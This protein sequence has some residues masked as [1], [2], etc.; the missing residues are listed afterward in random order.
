M[1][2]LRT[3]SVAMRKV[4]HGFD[5]RCWLPTCRMRFFARTTVR[6]A[7]ASAM[8]YVSGFW[9]WRS[10]PASTALHGDNRV[11]VIG[12]RHEDGVDVGAGEH[13]VV[14]AVGVD[15]DGRSRPCPCRSASTFAF[16]AASRF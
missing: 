1:R 16:A 14:V 4:F 7:I 13:L 15:L 3:A 8:S 5:E 2:P 10:L 11:P 12:R 9:T 6:S